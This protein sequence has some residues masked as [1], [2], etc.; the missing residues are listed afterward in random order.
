MNPETALLFGELLRRYRAAAGL[1]QEELAAR[2]GLTSQGIGLLERGVRQRPQ[3]S[4][5][6]LLADALGL[7]G[8]TRATFEA[9][10]RRP[11]LALRPQPAA[12]R[13]SAGEPPLVGRA[14]EL[15]L[16][17]R[18]C[19]GEG[20]PVLLLAGEPGIGK[21]RLLA[22]AAGRAQQSGWQVLRGGC[23]RRGGQEPYA[24]LLEALEHHINGQA[25]AQCRDALQGCAWL[26]RLLPELAAGSIEPLPGWTVPPEQERRLVFKAVIRYLANVAGSAGTL[27]V[28]DDLQWAGADALDLLATLARSA[29]EVPLRVVGAYRDT[30]VPP[31]AP[32]S[33]LLADLAHAG[34]ARQQSL[35]PLTAPEVGQLVDQLLA[36]TAA[37]AGTLRE[38]VA[39]RTGGVPYFVV[40]CVQSLRLEEGAWQGADIVP[41]TV[42]QSVRQRVAALPP[43]PQGVL[44]VAALL[45]R[46][47]Q[48]TLL[49]AVVGLPEDEVISALEAAHQL[50][51]LEAS[52]G[53]YRFAHDLVREVVEADVGPAR[54]AVLHRRAAEALEHGP[55]DPPVALLAYH[56]SRSDAQHKAVVYLER[57]GDQSEAQFAHTTAEECYRGLI[58]RL[59]DVGHHHDA[60]RAREKLGGVLYVLARYDEGLAV[61]E[62]AADCYRA[63]ADLESLARITAQIGR[64]HAYRG[65][66]RAGLERIQPVLAQLAMVGPSPGL[67]VLHLAMAALSERCGEYSQGLEAAEQA[68]DLARMLGNDSLP[69][70]AEQQRA[71]LLD[72]LG[73]PE[74]ALQVYEGIVPLAEVS[75]D[76]GVLQWACT[77]LAHIY[78]HAGEF[79]TSRRYIDRA[80]ELA[81]RAGDASTIAF[82]TMDR[83]FITFCSGDWSQ[84]RSDGER[85]VALDRQIGT[86]WT[87]AYTLMVLGFVSYGRGQWVEAARCLEQSVTLA[88]A[89][90]SIEALRMA[91]SML[92]E[93]DLVQGRPAAAYARVIPLLD[94]PGLE[95]DSAFLLPKLAWA[96]LE[97]G[98]LAQAAAVAAQAVAFAQTVDDF[99]NLVEALRVE[100]LIQIA[101]QRWAEAEHIL[102]DTVLRTKSKRYPWGEARL[103]EVYGLLHI[104]KGEPGPARERLEAALTIFRRLG[105]G[106]DVERLEAALA[107]LLQPG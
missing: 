75:G 51:L 32:L 64:L 73:Q 72:F 87:S 97:L 55:G 37:D 62:P 85:A 60:A 4:T 10:A 3:A 42:A 99:I 95:K 59:D 24:P 47:T 26:V 7:I 92:A 74:K 76:L 23:Q 19:H 104:R 5:V 105:A 43:K 18:H 38:R 45:G 84:A 80:L 71:G 46:V 49:A 1:T 21:S 58:E 67:A 22:E 57:A 100:A 83:G 29:A 106:K 82:Y 41:W 96:H 63:T 107:R 17:E 98:D 40:S 33:V 25:P 16:L 6:R 15:A 50:R 56:Y 77:N 48:P 35:T 12:T 34:M 102:T 2:S 91:Q 27:L 61:L 89:T 90:G 79:E 53:S 101:R 93:L 13:D 66:P 11:D 65:T 20:P 86:S 94:R 54:R 78:V 9:V 14:S 69:L 31:E 81:G 44:G 70:A 8:A 88:E 68:R 103:L 39:Q 28:L 36:D 52:A 30:E